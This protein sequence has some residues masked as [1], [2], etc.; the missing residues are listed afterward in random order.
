M[1]ISFHPGIQYFFNF[2]KNLSVIQVMTQLVED[3]QTAEKT[4]V[5]TEEKTE[6]ETKVGK[7]QGRIRS[8]FLRII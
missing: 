2:K 6:V 7:Y 1:L 3:L 5:K 8:L 4:E